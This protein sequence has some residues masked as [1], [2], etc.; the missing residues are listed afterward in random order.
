MGSPSCAV[1]RWL[2]S[3]CSIWAT[4]LDTKSL[5]MASTRM[6]G[7]GNGSERPN[8]LKGKAKRNGRRRQ[9]RGDCLPKASVAAVKHFQGT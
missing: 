3:A 2:S 5:W 8:Q 9:F 1:G 4:S 6:C 7:T